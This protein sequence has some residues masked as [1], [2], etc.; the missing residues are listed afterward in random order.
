MIARTAPAAFGSIVAWE[1]HVQEEIEDAD[2]EI[3]R[4]CVRST[5]HRPPQPEKVVK[6]STNI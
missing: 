5:I 1:K 4:P 3:P 6:R 2:L